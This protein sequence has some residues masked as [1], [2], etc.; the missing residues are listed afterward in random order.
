MSGILGHNLAVFGYTR[1]RTTWDN[2]INFVM[3]YAP[4]K[5]SIARPVDLQ[6]SR[7]LPLCYLLSRLKSQNKV[8]FR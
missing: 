8:R 7:A 4:D 5:G 1:P 2:G 3:N 6:Y